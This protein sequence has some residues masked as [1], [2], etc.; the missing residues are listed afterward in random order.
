ME[1][2]AVVKHFDKIEDGL[3]GLG[4]GCEMAA[5]DEL[6]FEGAPEGFHGG[7]VITVGFAAH[8]SDGLSVLEGVAVVETGILDTAIRMK[9][10]ACGWLTLSHRHIPSS[11]DE[12][13]IDVLAQPD[14]TISC[15]EGWVRE[16]V[17]L[18]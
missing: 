6:L 3:A 2:L 17:Q 9:N 11:E 5:V 10:Q 12:F 14:K 15:G 1:A 16:D 13:G 7:I 4:P 8:G 18:K